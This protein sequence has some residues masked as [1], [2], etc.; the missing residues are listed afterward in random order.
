MANTKSAK[1]NIRASARRETRNQPVLSA[2]K[3]GVKTANELIAGKSSE[4][5]AAVVSAV[6]DLDKAAG[7]G[8]IHPNNAARRKSR[9]MRRLNKSVAADQGPAA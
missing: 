8:V 3:T 7:H 4:A 2:L 6:S 9:L 5:P 1:K